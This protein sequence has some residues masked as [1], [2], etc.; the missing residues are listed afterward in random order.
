MQSSVVGIWLV[1]WWSM[2][3]ISASANSPNWGLF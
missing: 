3:G 1:F 2:V